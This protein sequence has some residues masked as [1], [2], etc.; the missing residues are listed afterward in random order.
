MYRN[1]YS[2]RQTPQSEPIPSTDQVPN[3][4]GGY[5]W[6]VDDW[7]RLDRFLILGSDEPTY[8]ASARTLTIENAD[9]VQ[10]CIK[11]D[12]ARTV[13][14]IA[15]ISEGG[16]APK[17]DPALFA[18]AMC[19]AADDAT[20]RKAALTALPRVARIGTHLF[21]FLHYVE[22]FR[23]WGRGLRNAVGAWYNDKPIDK[24]SY[25]TIKYRQRDGWTH[26][27]ALRLAHPTPSETHQALYHW[28]TQGEMQEG[29]PSLVA[30]FE[31]IQIAEDTKEVLATLA[32]YPGLPWETIP[33]QFLKE[34]RA[35]EA[36]LPKLPMTALFR[37]L[38]RMT[39]NGLIK[40]LSDAT[41]LA[42]QRIGDGERIRKARVHPIQVLA[43][44]ITYQSGHG[45]RG[46]LAW[47]PVSEVVDAL[48]AAFYL[49]FGNVEPTGKRT[50]IGLDVS[51]SMNYSTIAGIPGL[52]PRVGAAAM[53][54]I[55][56]RVEKRC[57][58][59]AFSREFIPF[60]VSPR[61]RLDDIVRRTDALP[62]GG[63]DCA[64]PM[65]WAMKH[66]VPADVF[67]VYT[68]SETWAGNIHPSQALQEHRRKTGILAKLV[69]VGMV[70]N[71][72]SIA[73]PNDGGMLDVVGFDTATPNII[74]DFMRQ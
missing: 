40:P 27:D 10:R 36:L 12:G 74:S 19:C 65:L 63:T 25:Q 18:L 7:T 62:F 5:A 41:H 45:T 2:T 59:M 68:D 46:K 43:A 58:I 8:Y 14:R 16:R 55:T 24:L 37:N 72:F 17:N 57:A 33:T 35:W 70:S 51:G 67:I 48:D 22:G 60:E 39:A 53:A 54:M 73:D 30:G 71:G 38:A 32:D 47:E 49:A 28:I 23:G 11:A 69:V 44:L 4:A 9:A 34:P 21:H 52:T 42:A 64:L 3:S 20:T 15:E 50:V 31:R 66:Q 56:A 1:Y 6:A 13:A 29:L 61:E 26:R